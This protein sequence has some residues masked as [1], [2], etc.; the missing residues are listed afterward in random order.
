MTLICPWT[1]A[2]VSRRCHLLRLRVR[3]DVNN[4]AEPV[5]GAG[6]RAITVKSNMYLRS[7]LI[8]VKAINVQVVS[9]AT[10][11][12]LDNGWDVDRVIGSHVI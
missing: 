2:T 11:V 3:P 9:R 6:G 8:C 12:L 5:F 10:W 1:I 7:P 4:V